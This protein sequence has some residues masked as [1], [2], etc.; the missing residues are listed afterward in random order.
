MPVGSVVYSSQEGEKLATSVVL[1]RSFWL[2]WVAFV[3]YGSLVPLEFPSLP[4]D[5]ALAQFSRIPM[6]QL[7]LPNRADWAANLVLYVPVGFFTALVLAE[8]EAKLR[9]LPGLISLFFGLLMAVL[10]EFAQ[11]YFPARTVSQN[12]LLAEGLGTALGLILARLGA[13]WLPTLQTILIRSWRRVA[14]ALVP[15]GTLAVLELSLF[16]YDLLIS[17]SKDGCA[18]LFGIWRR[19]SVAVGIWSRPVSG[20]SDQAERERACGR[21]TSSTS[22][23]T[24]RGAI[25][26]DLQQVAFVFRQMCAANAVY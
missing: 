11:L 21:G 26:G 5:Q 4:W 24:R 2:L 15:G 8:S 25:G 14:G 10:V 23:G 12:D 9:F 19:I 6:L 22:L 20:P 18:P 16:P 17:K 7:G 3:V 1:A 13:G